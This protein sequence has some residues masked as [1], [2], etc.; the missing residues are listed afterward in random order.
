ML[1]QDRFDR[2]AKRSRRM[3][4]F[5]ARTIKPINEV[6]HGID[7]DYRCINGAVWRRRRLLWSQTRVLVTERVPALQA[8]SREARHYSRMT[9]YREIVTPESKRFLLITAPEALAIGRS[10]TL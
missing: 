10:F 1:A 8:V 6:S 2:F 7:P 5:G 3:E 4:G 9:F